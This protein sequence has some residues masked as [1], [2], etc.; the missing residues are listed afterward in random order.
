MGASG[1][2][3]RYGCGSNGELAR[4]VERGLRRVLGHITRELV[5]IVGVRADPVECGNAESAVLRVAPHALDEVG[6]CLTP[7]VRDEPLGRL[8]TARDELHERT[9]PCL[10]R[11]LDDVRVG[12][13]ERHTLRLERDALPVLPALLSAPS[14]DVP[15]NKAELFD[16]DRSLLGLFDDA[17]ASSAKVLEVLVPRRRDRGHHRVVH[18]I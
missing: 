13:V 18:A 4:L 2:E 16:R 6:D 1:S 15:V 7:P 17:A 3:L 10:S 9:E 11:G 5:L 14:H 12:V 8:R